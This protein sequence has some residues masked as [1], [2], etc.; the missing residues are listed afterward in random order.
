M[1]HPAASAAVH[2]HSRAAPHQPKSPGPSAS[3]RRTLLCKPV[4][5]VVGYMVL[6]HLLQSADGPWLRALSICL[7]ILGLFSPS[8]STHSEA[9]VRTPVVVRPASSILRSFLYSVELGLAGKQ[10]R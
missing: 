7:A 1:A 9:Q 10:Q 5:L 8:P 4:L 2:I 3:V 6:P